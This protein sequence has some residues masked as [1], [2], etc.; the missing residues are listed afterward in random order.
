[1]NAISIDNEK[2]VKATDIARELGYT[3]DYVGQLCRAEKV[4]AQLVGRSWYVSEDSIRSHKKNRYRST[5]TV[6]RKTIASSLDLEAKDL[7]AKEIFSVPISKEGSKTKSH[8]AQES[9]YSRTVTHST[10]SYHEDSNELIPASSKIKTGSIQVSLG[11]AQVVKIKS[12]SQEYDFSP[13]QRPE[14]RFKGRLSV[15][16]IYD[17][18]EIHEELPEVSKEIQD[19]KKEH[20]PIE[21]AVVSQ[22]ETTT[23]GNKIH[24]RHLRKST[25]AKKRAL[26]IEHNPD[27]VL[28]M[29]RQRIVGRNPLGGTLKIEVPS[30]TTPNQSFGGYFIVISTVL[31]VMI[32]LFII[33][34]QAD[35]GVQDSL[36]STSYTFTFD[37]LRAAVFASWR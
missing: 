35:V 26:P 13:T 25:K 16:D 2:Y 31:S 19:T 3:A 11:D 5:K 33:G 34:L 8:Y 20:S 36:L 22:K 28:G 15:Q 10:P 27:G 1:M 29:Q 4:D 9:F 6:S 12:R 21:S 23:S 32:S 30:R 18:E 17:V 37:E 7:D 14:V 24:V